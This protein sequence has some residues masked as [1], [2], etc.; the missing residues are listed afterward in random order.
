MIKRE[1][2]FLKYNA[3]N[4]GPKGHRYMHYILKKGPI[5]M[6]RRIRFLS[7]STRPKK[8]QN[9]PRPFQKECETVFSF[10]FILA[11]RS[12]MRTFYLELLQNF[13]FEVGH[14]NVSIYFSLDT[15]SWT[16][17]LEKNFN[18]RVLPIKKCSSKCVPF[19]IFNFLGVLLYREAH[20]S[21]I[22]RKCWGDFTRLFLIAGLVAESSPGVCGRSSWWRMLMIWPLWWY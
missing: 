17:L 13:K 5:S 4:G 18:C 8:I 6:Y 3:Y 1:D 2:L 22:S 9:G 19:H 16:H 21:C 7:Q 12:E 10:I 14:K 20:T 15:L 11:G